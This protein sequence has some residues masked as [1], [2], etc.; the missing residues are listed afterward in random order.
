MMVS[1]LSVQVLR[2]H[3]QTLI[4]ERKIDGLSPAIQQAYQEYGMDIPAYKNCMQHSKKWNYLIQ[5]QTQQ[6]TDFN[7]YISTV[8]V[9]RLFF[10]HSSN[11]RV[12]FRMK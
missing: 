3:P 10:F 5:I 12:F 4:L 2:V 11:K 7:S 6:T 9:F 8:N 1:T